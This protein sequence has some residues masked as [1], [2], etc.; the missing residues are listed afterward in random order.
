MAVVPGSCGELAQGIIDGHEVLITCPISWQSQVSIRF[1]ESKSDDK[2][3][4]K[5]RRAVSLLFEK[6][7]INKNFSLIINSNL[8]RGKGM[9]SSSADIAASLKAAADLLG[10][11]ITEQ[12][13]KDIA[14]SIEPTD[15]VFFPGIVVFDHIKGDYY[16]YLG[17]PPAMKIAVFDCGGKVDT[18]AFNQRKDLKQL[19]L[20]GQDSFLESYRLI[21]EGIKTNNPV[22]VGKG[23]TISS[24]ANQHILPKK[25][26]E[27]II[28]FGNEHGAVGVN[29]AH[30]GTVIGILFDEKNAKD[31]EKCVE[32]VLAN[33]SV[34]SYLGSTNMISGGFY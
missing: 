6:Y 3:T 20:K 21:K 30:S 18:V 14:L 26:L 7:S 15:G 2:S 27:K 31:F 34:I 33:C 19:K 32:T 5:S 13:V 16:S 4:C 28:L 1:C 9:A 11:N 10:E 8:P 17:E 23:A 22:L 24:L 29:V 25:S 12:E